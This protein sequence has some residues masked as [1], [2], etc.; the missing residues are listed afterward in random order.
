MSEL[1]IICLTLVF[2]VW[3]FGVLAFSLYFVELE[4]KKENKKILKKENKQN[5]KKDN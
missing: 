1:F 4:D 5:E 3:C 2:V